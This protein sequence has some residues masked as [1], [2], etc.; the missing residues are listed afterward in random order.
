MTIAPGQAYAGT[1]ANIGVTV[2]GATQPGMG[3]QF[4]LPVQFADIEAIGG[5]A[6]GTYNNIRI[7][8]NSAT[9][10]TTF[11]TGRT[12][13]QIFGPN[14]GAPNDIIP[15]GFQFFLNKSN[16][17]PVTVYIDNV[18]VVAIPEPVTG[19]LIGLFAVIGGAIGRRRR[20]G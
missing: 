11:Q 14:P 15:T 2:F 16:D 18:R 17:Q 13:N 20:V 6:A 4:G 8:L 12:F 3:Q 5:K 1:F 10:P 7:D 9:H 19:T